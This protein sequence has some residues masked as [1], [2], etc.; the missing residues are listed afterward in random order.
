MIVDELFLNGAVVALH[1]G[2]NLRTPGIKEEGQK[3]QNQA[4]TSRGRLWPYR[5]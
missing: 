2:V 1:V 5:L 3:D 4:L